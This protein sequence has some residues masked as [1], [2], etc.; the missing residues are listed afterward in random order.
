MV[1]FFGLENRATCVFFIRVLMAKGLR[2]GV[3]YAGGTASA[4]RSVPSLH[5]SVG[6]CSGF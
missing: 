6:G 4:G 3:P 5:E 1:W 2:R